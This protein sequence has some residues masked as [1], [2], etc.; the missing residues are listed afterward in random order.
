MVYVK[1]TYEDG[2]KDMVFLCC[3]RRI[4]PSQGRSTPETEL[5]GAVTGAETGLRLS[6]LLNINDVRYWS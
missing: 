5:M 1:I 4:T 3:V 6:D 2:D